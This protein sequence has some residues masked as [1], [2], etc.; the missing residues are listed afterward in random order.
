MHFTLPMLSLGASQ[1]LIVIH[2]ASH[3]CTPNIASVTIMSQA[4]QEVRAVVERVVVSVAGSRVGAME[5]AYGPALMF[6]QHQSRKLVIDQ[7]LKRC[8]KVDYAINS[9]SLLCVRMRACVC[10]CGGGGG[11]VASLQLC[12]Y[13]ITLY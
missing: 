13:S 6:T 10:V 11:G 7:F 2:S 12:T 8:P 9:P 3:N 4:H 5:K 1:T